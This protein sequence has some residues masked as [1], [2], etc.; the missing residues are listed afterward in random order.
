MRLTGVTARDQGD[1]TDNALAEIATTA[2]LVSAAPAGRPPALVDAWI[3]LTALRAAFGRGTQRAEPDDENL[4]AADVSQITL[5]H[6][7]LGAVITGSPEVDG[8]PGGGREPGH[9]VLSDRHRGTTCPGG[10]IRGRTAP[11]VSW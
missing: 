11:A 8:S 3:A 5:E 10:G 7:L 1:D 2:V 6:L 4:S 9:R